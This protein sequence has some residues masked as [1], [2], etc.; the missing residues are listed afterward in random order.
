MSAMRLYFYDIHTREEL[1]V[2]GTDRKGADHA[3]SSEA[4]IVGDTRYMDTVFSVDIV[5]GRNKT[6][7]ITARDFSG[8][9]VAV[10]EWVMP[11]ADRYNPE[12]K[13]L[14]EWR[15]LIDR[16]QGF[17]GNE[18][19]TCNTA[20]RAKLGLAAR[21]LVPVD[22]IPDPEPPKVINVDVAKVE[23][24]AL[25]AA[26]PPEA[27][28][29]DIQKV[30]HAL[31]HEESPNRAVDFG[32]ARKA[33]TI[34]TE[35]GHIEDVVEV[36]EEG[37]AAYVAAGGELP[38]FQKRWWLPTI[39]YGVIDAIN[40]TC[41][42]QGSVKYA[43]GAADADY[44]GHFVSVSFNEFRQYWVTQYTWSGRNVLARGE[45]E[46]ALRAGLREYERG[47]LGTQIMAY[48]KTA[49]DA[50]LAKELGYQPYSKAA[51]R[52]HDA[53]WRTDLHDLV[54]EAMQY[55]KQ[56]TAPL[57]GVLANAKDKADY[58][59]KKEA[60]LAERRARRSG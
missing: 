6:R 58:E 54:G 26:K 23:R 15:V 16:K 37:K 33:L 4:G 43:M 56:G 36:T 22:A 60:M 45:L 40:R 35:R 3:G 2:P 7:T 9:I 42:A 38:T 27:A 8:R 41:A 21:D 48:V 5:V 47:A 52:A 10:K 50:A 11:A 17:M 51:Q 25:E 14:I 28:E 59:T 53:T 57:L 20:G 29:E 1:C 13:P 34:L 44:N 46:S 55:E 30:L 32:V 19:P 49:E 39:P 12:P 18:S 31:V 24:E